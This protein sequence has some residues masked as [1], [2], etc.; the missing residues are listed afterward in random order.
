M[1]ANICHASCLDTIWTYLHIMSSIYYLHLPKQTDICTI[2]VCHI[3]ICQ[4]THL[5]KFCVSN[6]YWE[7]QIP[8]HLVSRF[9]PFKKVFRKSTIH[10]CRYDTLPKTNSS[11]LKKCAIP[12]RNDRLRGSS[13]NH[14]NV[15]VRKCYFQGFV[16]LPGKKN[17][18]TTKKHKQKGRT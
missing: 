5:K 18:W 1:Q 10:L 8:H 11:P 2:F 9:K 17:L 13:S 7:K 3:I 14:R 6:P 12:K 16:Y 4:T 15:Q